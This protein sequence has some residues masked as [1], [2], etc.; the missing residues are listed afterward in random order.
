MKSIYT[1]A[2]VILIILIGIYYFYTSNQNK[3]NNDSLSP[4]PSIVEIADAYTFTNVESGETITV[5]FNN[6]NNTA[7]LNSQDYK[8]LVFKQTI[9]ASGARYE[10][11]D[12]GLILWNKGNDISLM[13]GEEVLFTGTTQGGS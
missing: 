12:T 4:S 9:S 2:F 13:K 10:N 11:I 7:I 6:E 1:I 5:T 8:D 3:I